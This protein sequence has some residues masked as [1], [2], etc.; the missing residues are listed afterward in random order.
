M[1][2]FQMSC[3]HTLLIE[4]SLIILNL[5]HKGIWEMRILAFQT[6][7]CR[8]CPEG[9]GRWAMCPQVVSRATMMREEREGPQGAVGKND[10]VNPH[11]RVRGSFSHEGDFQ[12]EI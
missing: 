2:A 11:S 3:K 7:R 10:G 12:A 6:R 9:L 4:T 5:S 8:E 1:F